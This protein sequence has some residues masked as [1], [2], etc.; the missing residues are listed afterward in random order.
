[1]NLD[2]TVRPPAPKCWNYRHCHHITHTE[3]WRH[4]IHKAWHSAWHTIWTQYIVT[5]INLWLPAT[6]KAS[7]KVIFTPVARHMPPEK[8]S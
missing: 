3:P 4:F 8:G 6:G 5:H 1:M 2:F 7:S